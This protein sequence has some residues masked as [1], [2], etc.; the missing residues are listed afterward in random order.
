MEMGSLKR[1]RT[2]SVSNRTAY[3]ALEA[4]RGTGS[5]SGK[6]ARGKRKS[7]HKPAVDAKRKREDAAAAF[8]ELD[9]H[10]DGPA[11]AGKSRI[12]LWM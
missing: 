9:I 3:Q 4:T 1:R 10:E 12:I 6:V 5:A 7:L 2:E 8:D 11:P